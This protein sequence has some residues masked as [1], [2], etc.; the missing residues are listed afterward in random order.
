[1]QCGVY[2][3][4]AS[5]FA[6]AGVSELAPDI[7]VELFCDDVGT[8]EHSV[9]LTLQDASFDYANLGY[10]LRKN[11]ISA[12]SHIVGLHDEKTVFKFQS[13]PFPSGQLFTVSIITSPPTIVDLESLQPIIDHIVE[14]SKCHV[15]STKTDSNG[16]NARAM[17]DE[18]VTRIGNL[19]R[20]A[21]SFHD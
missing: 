8:V 17:Y 14:S 13:L 12:E 1:V 20:E 18:E 11:N 19:I 7:Y 4:H 15:K 16:A 10:F 5:T 21:R 3:L 2:L 9:E 6:E